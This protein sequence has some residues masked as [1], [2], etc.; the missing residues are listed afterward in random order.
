L[1]CC[2]SRLAPLMYGKMQGHSSGH[3]SVRICV[4]ISTSVGLNSRELFCSAL[5][6]TPATLPCLS[7]V[8]IPQKRMKT[9]SACTSFAFKILP[10]ICR[11]RE[12]LID[13]IRLFCART[14]ALH[15]F[16]CESVVG[17]A[18]VHAL[19]RTTALHILSRASILRQTHSYEC[20][21]P[22]IFRLPVRPPSVYLSLPIT[23][24]T[25]PC[26]ASVLVCRLDIILLARDEG[27]LSVNSVW[28]LADKK[29]QK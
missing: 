3:Y 22:D 17:C 20:S 13:T 12:H 9:E 28:P 10:R 6:Q 2:H 7:T 18:C 14:G 23:F 11:C 26:V 27:L 5:P 24:H 1:D 4:C 15:A 25:I 19:A 21:G 16:V 8:N 29:R